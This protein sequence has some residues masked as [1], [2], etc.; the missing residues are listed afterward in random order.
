MNDLKFWTNQ[1]EEVYGGPAWRRCMIFTGRT[2][3]IVL[4]TLRCGLVCRQEVIGHPGI[5]GRIFRSA[6][7]G[8]LDIIIF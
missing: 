2:S 7:H 3:L 6:L 8:E 5:W 4:M 1:S